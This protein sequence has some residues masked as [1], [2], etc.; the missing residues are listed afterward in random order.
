MQTLTI[1]YANLPSQVTASLSSAQR[2]GADDAPRLQAALDHLAAEIEAGRAE[3]G[4]LELPA[5]TLR[6]SE[7]LQV[8]SNITIKGAGAELL[9]ADD[10][11]A[12]FAE[13]A[14]VIRPTDGFA[15]EPGSVK[16]STESFGSANDEAYLLDL[17]TS[18]DITIEGVAFHGPT[19]HGAIYGDIITDVTIRDSAIVD[20]QFAGIRNFSGTRVTIEDNRFHDAGGQRDGEAFDE[21]VAGGAIYGTWWDDAVVTG[22]TFTDTGEKPGHLYGVK[23]F[24]WGSSEI[25]NNTF[26]LKQGFSIEIAHGNSLDVEI[27]HNYLSGPVSLPKEGGGPY[28]DFAGQTFDIH[29]NVFTNSYALE[30]P[31]DGVRVDS[32][33]FAFA[34]GETNNHGNLFSSFASSS[35]DGTIAFTNNLVLNPGRGVFWA[36]GIIEDLTFANNHIVVDENGREDTGLFGFHGGTDFSGVSIV[37]NVIE[38]SGPGRDLVRND[39]SGNATIENNRLTGVTDTDRYDNPGTGD[40]QGLDGPLEFAV[41]ANG[42][43]RVDGDALLEIARDGLDPRAAVRAELADDQD[44]AGQATPPPA[45]DAPAPTLP[46][47]AEVVGEAGQVTVAQPDGDTWFT[48]DFSATIED[49]VVVLGP[50]EANGGQAAVT[51]VRNV[52]DEGFEFQIDEWA[53]LDGAH[54]AETVS[55]VAVSAGT[56]E[57]A[58]GRTIVA[59]TAQADHQSGSVSFGTTL[60][61]AVVFSEVVTARGADPVTTRISNV[62]DR[63]FDLVLQEEEAFRDGGHMVEDVA[64]VAI[65]AGGGDGPNVYVIDGVDHTGTDV[66]F[67]AFDEAPVLLADIQTMNGGDTAALRY[68]DLSTDG[69][70]LFLE[71]ETSLDDETWHAPETIAVAVIDDGL[72]Y[73]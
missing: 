46:D 66:A 43:V 68:H 59:G 23:G 21:G 22:N 29:H 10:P 27:H 56:H 5:G 25:A 70:S 19:V 31:R 62:T 30:L 24:R 33:I 16:D 36:Q 37:D 67:G 12:G 49:A 51:R 1:D 69:A 58:D 34:P 61:D 2:T 28:G 42:T 54:V 9:D 17:N 48:V 39:A 52:T 53:Y 65:E 63:G 60:D 32:N 26:D 40:A 8:P 20:T 35:S 6:I 3:D 64:F 4:V 11:D 38:V 47:G 18:N 55:W 14:T 57:L 7:S 71:E 73:A 45:D 15:F 41:G 72:F 13:G 50:V 44:G